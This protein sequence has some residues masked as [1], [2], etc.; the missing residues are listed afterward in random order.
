MWLNEIWSN[1][2]HYLKKEKKKKVKKVPIVLNVQLLLRQ[3]QL[4]VVLGLYQVGF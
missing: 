1:I 2:E 4:S 3:A